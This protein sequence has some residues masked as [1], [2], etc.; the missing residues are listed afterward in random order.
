MRS[1][2]QTLLCIALCAAC[3]LCGCRKATPTPTPRPTSTPTLIPSHTPT[4][5][6]TPTAEDAT[7]EGLFGQP[8][9]ASPTPE[10]IDV[11][12]ENL[13]DMPVPGATPPGTP[14]P[15]PD[16]GLADTGEADKESV[17]AAPIW[18]T[19]MSGALLMALC[20]LEAG[21]A[22]PAIGLRIAAEGALVCLAGFPSDQPVRIAL[23][24]P[25][26]QL[27]A[28]ETGRVSVG[29][30]ITVVGLD[31]E[32]PGAQ[33]PGVWRVVVELPGQT[34]E[35]QVTVAERGTL[36]GRVVWN[37]RPIANVPVTL[38]V[39]ASPQAA[40]LGQARTSGEGRFSIADIPLGSVAIYAKPDDPAY[41]VWA[42]EVV[43]VRTDG[44]TDAGDI[45]VCRGFDPIA[46]A[47]GAALP[48]GQPVRF[49]WPTVPGAAEYELRVFTGGK[50]AFQGRTQATEVS[51]A[52]APNPDYG[53]RVDGFNPQ[54]H[55]IAC[56][57][58]RTF[59]VE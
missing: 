38:R 19:P 48:R 18:I 53:W 1:L 54:G 24:A 40:I 42:L 56:S 44:V 57:Y 39:E 21:E 20:G 9:T 2:T 6:D 52:L 25:E 41:W 36:K 32:L 58:P 59:R 10:S 55:I 3:A 50:F 4:P 16:T 26:A 29:Q 17:F 13:W 15:T 34:F 51:V 7:R 14:T 23:Y 37:E 8:V 28:E 12:K 35:K 33:R 45:A 5:R 49:A 30:P 11:D 47:G 46:P 22:M 27:A 31:L 43:D